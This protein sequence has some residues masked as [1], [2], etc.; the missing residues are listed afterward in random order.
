MAVGETL[1]VLT[2]NIDLSVGLIL[3]LAAYVT[4]TMLSNDPTI[5]APVIIGDRD[6][7]RRD[8]R[9]RE[10]GPG[11]LW[12]GPGDR[13]H[14]RDAGDLPGRPRR[15]SGAKT[16]TTDTLPQWMLDLAERHAP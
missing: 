4:G 15:A 3:G 9:C 12:T 5:P 2:R 16:V 11:R 10:R 6:R 14:A 7:H 1:A 8:A 13:H